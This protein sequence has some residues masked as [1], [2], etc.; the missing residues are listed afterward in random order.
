MK[1]RL[2][3]AE[4]ARVLGISEDAA[5]NNVKSGSIPGG[6]MLYRTEG[7]RERWVIDREVLGIPS[8]VDEPAE[9]RLSHSAAA[10]ERERGH[11]R[12]LMLHR[13][14]PRADRSRAVDRRT[15]AS[16]KL[17]SCAFHRKKTLAGPAG[18]RASRASGTGS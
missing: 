6:V 11:T 4:V 10:E 7:G 8:G 17:S 1:R 15:R 3:I 13:T 18:T 16:P 5:R 14:T 12:R 2:S 9:E